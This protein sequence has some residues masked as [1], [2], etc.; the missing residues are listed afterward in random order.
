MVYIRP[1]GCGDVGSGPTVGRG[2]GGVGG[3]VPK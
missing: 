2:V 1:G 3:D